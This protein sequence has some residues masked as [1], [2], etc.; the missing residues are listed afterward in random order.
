MMLSAEVVP[1]WRHVFVCDGADAGAGRFVA[2]TRY[3]D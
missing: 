1:E 3:S 2:L